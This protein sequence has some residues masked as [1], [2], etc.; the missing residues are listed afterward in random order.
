MHPADVTLGCDFNFFIDRI[1]TPISN[2]SKYLN[3]SEYLRSIT[4]GLSGHAPRTIECY[5]CS[6]GFALFSKR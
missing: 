6:Y 3:T 1:F 5:K 4:V 2:K